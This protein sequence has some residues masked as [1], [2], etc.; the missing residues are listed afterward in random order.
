MI[1]FVTAKVEG[2][3]APLAETDQE[4]ASEGELGITSDDDPSLTVPAHA[5]LD[6]GVPAADLS[7]PSWALDRRMS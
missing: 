3:D 2:S 6:L 5:A 1:R 4:D 7:R